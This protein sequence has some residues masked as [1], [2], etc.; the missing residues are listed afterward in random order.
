MITYQ[1]TAT[2]KNPKSLKLFFLLFFKDNKFNLK[3][4][5]YRNKNKKKYITILKSPHVNKKAQSQLEYKLFSTKIVISA[6]NNSQYLILL[7]K[8]KSKLFPEIKIKTK[9]IINK[10]NQF[11]L[12]TQLLNPQNF[13][14]NNFNNYKNRLINNNNIKNLNHIKM[15]DYFGEINLIQ[16]IPF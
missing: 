4:T 3:K 6:Q 2:S 14:S 1:I 9:I 5:F 7:K 8:I 16:N 11:Q 15:F 12:Q 10:L 13:S